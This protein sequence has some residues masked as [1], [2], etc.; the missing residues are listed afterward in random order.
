MLRIRFQNRQ[1]FKSLI[2]RRT[3]F[4]L[5]LTI[6][7]MSFLVLLLLS[8]STLTRVETGAS[9]AFR[10]INIARQ[11]A[12]FA[13]NIAIGELQ[14]HAG[15]DNRAT[16]QA[17]ILVN[18]NANIEN[19]YWTGVWPI[20]TNQLTAP[21]NQITGN[22]TWLVS[23]VTPDPTTAVPAADQVQ[24][25]G[26]NSIDDTDP[27]NLVVVKKIAIPGS[28]STQYGTTSTIGNYAYWVGDE[29][30]KASVALTNK[31]LSQNNNWLGS[32]DPTEKTR[33][34]QL[35]AMRNGS[36]SFLS[37]QTTFDPDETANINLLDKVYSRKQLLNLGNLTELRLKKNFHDITNRAMGILSNPTGGLKED[38]SL[39]PD[40]L[41]DAFEQ[42]VDY[43]K[44][45]QEQATD[46]F[47]TSSSDLRRVYNISAPEINQNIV[48]SMAPVL[49]DFYLLFSFYAST[50]GDIIKIKYVMNFEFWNPYSSAIIPE[51]LKI[52]INNLPNII[53]TFSD[54]STKEFNLQELLGGSSS[55]PVI[56]ILKFS[57]PFGDDSGDDD[58]IW[59]PGR[60][61]NWTGPKNKGSVN[62]K[63]TTQNTGVFY[64]KSFDDSYWEGDTS[65]TYPIS[66]GTTALTFGL[67]NKDQINFSINIKNSSDDVLQTISE[68]KMSNFD[69]K[70]DDFDHNKTSYK[71]GI[72]LE[73]DENESNKHHTWN[74]MKW[75][76]LNDPRKIN[77]TVGMIDENKMY[78]FPN[79]DSPSDYNNISGTYTNK[80]SNDSELF[81]RVMG[82]GGKSFNEDVPLFEIIRQPILSVGSLQHIHINES[83][84]YTI[85]N[86]WGNVDRWNKK[87]D[88]YFFSGLKSS[89]S[90]PD[91]SANAAFPNSRLKVVNRQ[92]TNLD[93][94]TADGKNSGQH[95]LVDGSFNINSTS[96]EAWNTILTSQNINKWNYVNLNEFGDQDTIPTNSKKLESA[97]FRYSQSAQETY[98]SQ[99]TAI[100]S[101]L[102]RTEYF[103]QGVKQLSADQCRSLAKKIVENIRKITAPDDQPFSSI[104]HFLKPQNAFPIPE[105]PTQFRSVI[106]QAIVE[107]PTINQDGRDRV[108]YHL[109]ASYLTQ[110][111]IMTAIAPFVNTRSDTFLI[112][113]YGE[114][115]NPITDE[116]DGKAWCEAV[117]QR[118]P[119]TVDT[120]DDIVDPDEDN[121]PFGRKFKIVSFRWLSAADI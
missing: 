35:M 118:F 99:S 66:T 107:V 45:M 73:L 86:S 96:L 70:P 102:P 43:N 19:P 31:T 24:M 25:V 46:N 84:P 55:S 100:T 15:Q 101:D 82:A 61:Y 119:E 29:G 111:D 77:S 16:A 56:T 34:N 103:R 115:Q 74:R 54:T 116:I 120:A 79:G 39:A 71:F 10:N 65:E 81:D 47:I 60:V 109:T 91:I 67:K 48:F 17:N 110:A 51:D 36:E 87:F 94:I 6:T 92:N 14:E 63:T 41:G 28:A 5:I 85:G 3:G 38:L 69:Y 27:T 78:Y 59:L 104:E 113:A 89:S 1:K 13:L 2:E 105:E 32:Y 52:E 98:E 40:L 108:I 20:T 117:V 21:D 4:A 62:I 50:P 64:I 68:I 90:E 106:E 37:D 30:V 76:R 97:F 9:N 44:N 23:G 8:L 57:E 33:L 7:L 58:I 11:N 18:D 12:L 26:S 75:A 88:E 80:L 22:P 121:Y 72:R 83:R 112:R 49:T 42:Y 95:F 93:T 114:V 53:M